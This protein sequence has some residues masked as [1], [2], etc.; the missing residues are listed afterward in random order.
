M[1]KGI[2]VYSAI[3]MNTGQ[4][5]FTDLASNSV[6][7]FIGLGCPGAFNGSSRYITKSLEK[8]NLSIQL[9]NQQNLSH[10][11][12]SDQAKII[13]PLLNAF[14]G[15]GNKISLNLLSFYNAIAISDLDIQPGKGVNINKLFLIGGSD[16]VFK[17]CNED[18]TVVPINDLYQINFSIISSQNKVTC[19]HLRHD[20]LISDT[21][22][23][24][25]IKSKLR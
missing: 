9:L 24:E 7:T 21:D 22:V 2:W 14:L 11:Y 3:D 6:D 16:E 18:D 17:V 19:L 8:G 10:V 15:G 1:V 13:D 20:Q 23:N 25:Y 12:K 5:L 4:Y